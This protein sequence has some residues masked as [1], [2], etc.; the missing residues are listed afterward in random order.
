M[1]VYTVS[2]CVI[3]FMYQVL[4]LNKAMAFN[5]QGNLGKIVTTSILMSLEKT[6]ALSHKNTHKY[7]LPC[8][9]RD[10]EIKKDRERKW[11]EKGMRDRDRDR[12]GVEGERFKNIPCQIFHPPSVSVP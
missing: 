3:Q 2:Q 11:G 12:G 6:W 8:G 7:V 10:M 5:Q 9:G 4:M 1:Q